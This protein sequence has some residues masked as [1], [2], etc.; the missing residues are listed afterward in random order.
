MDHAIGTITTDTATLHLA[1]GC[2]RPYIALTVDGWSTSTP[3]GNCKLEVK[4]SRFMTS[5]SAIVNTV[6][7]W[8]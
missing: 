5:L 7:S 6:E 4:Y 2:P 3:R 1:H 8:L